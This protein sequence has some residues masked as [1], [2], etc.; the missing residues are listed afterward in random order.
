MDYMHLGQAASLVVIVAGHTMAT[1][2]G[3]KEQRPPVW[4]ALYAVPTP[5]RPT[6]IAARARATF[7]ICERRPQPAMSDSDTDPGFAAL[8]LRVRQRID[9]AFD[10][11]A[12]HRSTTGEPAAKR[13]R[14]DSQSATPGGFIAGDTAQAGGF[15][16]D[17]GGGGFLPEDGGAAGGFLPES[18]R[19]DDA[20]GHDATGAADADVIPFNMIPSA[21]QAL[22]LQ[23][24]DE[25]VLSV[26][27][28]A[29]TG[30][31]NKGAALEDD[32]HLRVRRKDWRAVCAALLDV[33]GSAD[34][35]ED[36]DEDDAMEGGMDDEPA[37]L[38]EPSG[39][40]YVASEDED[41]DEDDAMDDDD[42]DGEYQAGGFVRSKSS[43]KATGKTRKGRGASSSLSPVASDEEDIE[44]RPK[45]VTARQKAEARRAF[46]MFFPDVPD[47]ELDKQRLMIK[48]ITRMA[49]LIS[50][51]LTAEEIVQMLSAF[52]TQP[53]K[54]MS[55]ADF[56]QM[57]VTAKLA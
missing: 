25:D 33:G 3:S 35:D 38:S 28:N 5:R 42:D 10:R 19:A 47:T 41:G 43:R 55:L 32:A 1:K 23:P 2:N 29:A 53:D 57:M 50:L 13:R 51:K 36:V 9:R 26:L 21:L 37:D 7:A 11:Y 22:D 40:E 30:W 39:D 46:A 34:E 27:R 20:H 15:V 48:D 6:A 52:S 56:E 12:T 8:P 16:N 49:S 17:F 14:L 54:S 18:P 4:A 31:E 45:R 24:D 44:G